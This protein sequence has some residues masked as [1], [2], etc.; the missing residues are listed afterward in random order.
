MND[1]HIPETT[2][3]RPRLHFSPRRHWINDPNGLFVLNGQYHVYFQ[4]NPAGA[5]WGEIGWGHAVSTDLI[6]WD[7]RPLALPAT[8]DEMA[9]SGSVVIDER[10]TCGL[11]PA[12]STA[13][14]LLAY[15]TRYDRR[16]KVQSQCLAYSVDGGDSFVRWSGNPLLDIGSLEFRDPYVFRHEASGRW[17]ML[18]VLALERKL[19]VYTSDDLLQW[20]EASSF[21][22]AGASADTIWEVPV[23]L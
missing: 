13:P 5:T 22:P 23:L 11:A 1:S 21:G 17:V 4:H 9:F 19:V 8:D 2:A 20:R 10:N 7:E 14:V 16:S 18:I 12:G 6:H 15:Y 3:W